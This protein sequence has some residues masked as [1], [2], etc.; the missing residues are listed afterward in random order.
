MVSDAELLADAE[1]QATAW[2]SKAGQ[3]KS[4]YW[5]SQF[6]DEMFD[7]RLECQ[8]AQETD[9][10]IWMDVAVERREGISPKQYRDIT[11]MEQIIE[12]INK[13]LVARRLKS[14]RGWSDPDGN[15]SKSLDW[16]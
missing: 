13:E 1:S 8:S 5:G 9:L 16:Y 2:Q 10:L 4:Y 12:V 11:R 7:L 14:F 3:R 15:D 6:S